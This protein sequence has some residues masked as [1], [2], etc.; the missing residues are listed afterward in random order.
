MVGRAPGTMSFVQLRLVA[1]CLLLSMSDGYDVLA[2]SFAAP[3]VAEEW[4]LSGAAIGVLLSAGLFGMAGGSVFI[5]PLA[6]RVGRRP[7]LV[8]SAVLV[9]VGVVLSAAA[10]DET[11]LAVLRVVTGLGVGSILPCITVLVAEFTPIRRRT[12]VLGGLAVG[13]PLGGLV[14]GSVAA[15]IIESHG[16][17]GVFVFGAV[18]AGALA[19]LATAF[20]P[21]SMAFL[22][23]RGTPAAAAQLMKLR[24]RVDVDG[25]ETAPA[26]AGTPGRTPLRS[27][28]RR[29]GAARVAALCVACVFMSAGF[30]FVLSWTPRLLQ[31]AGWSAQQGIGG[32]ILVN[33]GGMVGCVLITIG[34][35]RLTAR[36]LTIAFALLGS[37]TLVAFSLWATSLGG[38][39]FLAVLLGVTLN[40]A[41]VGLYAVIPAAF[42]PEVRA[43]AAGIGIGVGRIGAIVAPLV[44]GALVDLG[45]PMSTIF[46][47]FAVPVALGALATWLIRSPAGTPA[48][49][50]KD[51]ATRT[52]SSS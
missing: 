44:A 18:L 6:D 52:V 26:G 49:A 42:P 27:L 51:P 45:R 31:S 34:G 43:T 41:I 2:M 36:T 30:Y 11:Q 12:A 8:W 13:F 17:R 15:L 40:A 1:L 39:L 16:W 22:S 10:T 20:V 24:A 5:A 25:L 19:L 9:T 35:L 48:P 7:V 33:L 28:F 23:R 29:G 14:G 21:E 38:T 4:H 50:A 47:L 37:V 3:S 32:A 46:F